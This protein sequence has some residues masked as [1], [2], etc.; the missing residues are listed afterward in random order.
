MRSAS[1]G[2]LP[3]I[4]CGRVSRFISTTGMLISPDGLRPPS[5]LWH[6]MQCTYPSASHLLI[7]SIPKPYRSSPSCLFNVQYPMPTKNQLTN[8][9][10]TYI[11]IP[12]TYI[13][14]VSKSKQLV[15]ATAEVPSLP[16]YA[17]S[18]LHVVFFSFPFS[19]FSLL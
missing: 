8:L 9:S 16:S 5:S 14:R 6:S 17:N 10:Y 12:S 11:H 19:F 1:T 3:S 18:S 2:S 7:L 4:C 13:S 15:V